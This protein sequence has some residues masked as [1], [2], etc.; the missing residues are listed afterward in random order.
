MQN[1]GC[2]LENQFEFGIAIQRLNGKAINSRVFKHF[3]LFTTRRA[4]NAWNELSGNVLIVAMFD[5]NSITR[6]E[7]DGQLTRGISDV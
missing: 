3:F 2:E 6:S 5:G 4:V 7:N 1:S